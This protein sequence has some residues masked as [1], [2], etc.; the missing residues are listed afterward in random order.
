MMLVTLPT[1][2][3]ISSALAHLDTG[4]C[5][6]AGIGD[7]NMDNNDAAA[8]DSEACCDDDTMED[9]ILSYFSM[10]SLSMAGMEL[11]VPVE[12]GRHSG[13]LVPGVELPEVGGG[14]GALETGGGQGVEPGEGDDRG[15]GGRGFRGWRSRALCCCSYNILRLRVHEEGENPLQQHDHICERVGHELSGAI[16]AFGLSSR[17]AVDS[18]C[19]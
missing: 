14:E 19:L 11:P 15:K 7:G 5:D 1:L 9:T 17:L 13:A 10:N 3:L 2:F 4:G 12:D 16:K 18:R 8:D 6:E